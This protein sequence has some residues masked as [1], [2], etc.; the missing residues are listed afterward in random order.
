[1]SP[2]QSAKLSFLSRILKKE[3]NELKP[4]CTELGL[5]IDSIQGATDKDGTKVTSDFIAFYKTKGNRDSGKESKS[6]KEA[7]TEANEAV[8]TK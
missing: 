2:V 1:M 4:F 7:I 3:T 8:K 5:S 6:K